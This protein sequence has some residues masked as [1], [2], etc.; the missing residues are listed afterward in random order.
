MDSWTLSSARECVPSLE[1]HEVPDPIAVMQSKST[2]NFHALVSF[3]LWTCRM[4]TLCY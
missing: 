4:A 2:T 1:Q 3:D